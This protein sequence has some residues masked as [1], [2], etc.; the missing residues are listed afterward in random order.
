VLE[1]K[2]K[3][4]KR[5]AAKRYVSPIEFAEVSAQLKRKEETL[6]YLELAYEQ[7]AP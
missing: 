7:H 6:R 5:I 4:Y 2:L 3:R 1:W